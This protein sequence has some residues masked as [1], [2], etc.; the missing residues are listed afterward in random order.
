MPIISAEEKISLLKTCLSLRKSRKIFQNAT[1]S[2]LKENGVFVSEGSFSEMLNR[3]YEYHHRLADHAYEV[4]KNYV[5]E[6][7]HH[8][9]VDGRDKVKAVKHAL[10]HALLSETGVTEEDERTAQQRLPGSYI[11]YRKSVVIPGIIVVGFCQITHE[12]STNALLFTEKTRKRDYSEKVQSDEGFV[13]QGY[14]MKTPTKYFGMQIDQG[15]GFPRTT[16]FDEQYNQQGKVTQLTGITMG[17]L[18]PSYFTSQVYMSRY[19][20]DDISWEEVLKVKSSN[21]NGSFLIGYHKSDS[22]DNIARNILENRP[23][24]SIYL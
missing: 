22:V 7:Q 1:V 21:G 3:P 6:K 11:I 16:V 18:G 10:F 2:Y 20:P 13:W 19:E 9:E 14:I 12:E 5:A 8:V 15:N 17:T 4:L 24:N 23:G